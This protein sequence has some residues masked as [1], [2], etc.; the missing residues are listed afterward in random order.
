M[1][2]QSSQLMVER[3]LQLVHQGVWVR[4]TISQIEQDQQPLA[5]I[6]HRSSL[7]RK[8]FWWIR[9]FIEETEMCRGNNGVWIWMSMHSVLDMPKCPLPIEYN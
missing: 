8:D 3:E 7:V 6:R 5:I 4:S 9:L 2:G 1:L